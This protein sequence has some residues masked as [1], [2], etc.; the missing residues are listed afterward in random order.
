MCSSLISEDGLPPDQQRI[1]AKCYHPTGKFISFPK[2]A[3]DQSITARFEQIVRLYP[4]RLAV[5]MGSRAITYDELNRDANRIARAILAQNGEKKEPC[6]VVAGLYTPM[7]AA[8][9]GVLKTGRV[10]VPLDPTYPDAQ[11]ASMLKDVQAPLIITNRTLYP[12][13]FRYPE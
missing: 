1:R 13:L 2:E 6:R 10:Y 11:L 3:L 4:D 7:I 5:R 8:L 9:L 12:A